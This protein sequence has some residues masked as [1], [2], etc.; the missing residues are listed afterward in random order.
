MLHKFYKDEGNTERQLKKLQEMYSKEIK[1]QVKNV[2][3]I[4]VKQKTRKTRLEIY[5]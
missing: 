5:G 4:A 1:E 2:V 3:G